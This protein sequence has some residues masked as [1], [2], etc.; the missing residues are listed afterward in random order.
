MRRDGVYPAVE[1]ADGGSRGDTQR[2]DTGKKGDKESYKQVHR[3][4]RSEKSVR[5]KMRQK[6]AGQWRRRESSGCNY[7]NKRREAEK[8]GR[9]DTQRCSRNED[10]FRKGAKKVQLKSQP[11]REDLRKAVD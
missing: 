8:G 4:G 7:S 9:Q 11:S 10:R 3:W 6:R 1:S 2:G 5:N